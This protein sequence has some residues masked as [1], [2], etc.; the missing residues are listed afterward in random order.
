MNR[1]IMSFLAVAVLAAP[2]L[3]GC[4]KESSIITQ[5]SSLREFGPPHQRILFKDAEGFIGT[6]EDSPDIVPQFFR[7][8]GRGLDFPQTGFAP[9]WWPLSDA[10]NSK[11]GFYDEIESEYVLLDRDGSAQHVIANID[12]EM[13]SFSNGGTY[14]FGVLPVGDGIYELIRESTDSGARA[15]MYR[16]PEN[17]EIGSIPSPGSVGMTCYANLVNTSNPAMSFVG[18]FNYEGEIVSQLFARAIEPQISPRYARVAYIEGAHGPEN[19]TRLIVRTPS[20]GSV[21]A[22]VS[23]IAYGTGATNFAWSPDEN[24][25]AMFVNV[26]TTEPKLIVIDF[27]GENA[28]INEIDVGRTYALGSEDELRWAYPTWDPD[29]LKLAF[30]VVNDENEGQYDIM[31]VNVDGSEPTVVFSGLTQL[32]HVQWRP[33]N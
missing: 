6:L 3:V 10:E 13:V 23:F 22:S 29:G 17:Y 25:I 26:F 24:K 31:T 12:P 8:V 4:E 16:T 15:I 1:S 27:S 11:I 18:C 30:T 33:A 2:L 7:N 20:L 5:P 32:S 21:E 14:I 28:V 19:A 9:R